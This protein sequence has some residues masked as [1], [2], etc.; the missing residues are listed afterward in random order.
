MSDE[1]KPVQAAA[2]AA[3][4]EH[5]EGGGGGGRR[6]GGPGGGGGGAAK[7]DRADPEDRAA[8]VAGPAASASIS[9]RRKFASSASRRST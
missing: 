5:R 6:E 2:P 9:A 1:Q 7:A 3:P 4:R 8:Q